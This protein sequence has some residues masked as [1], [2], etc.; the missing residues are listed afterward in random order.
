[1][2]GGIETGFWRPGVGG[3]ERPGHLLEDMRQAGR[4]WRDGRDLTQWKG[5][6]K[7]ERN[8]GVP[9]MLAEKG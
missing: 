6:E 9:G 7:L 3:P 5:E 2:L 1:M 4:A 8:M